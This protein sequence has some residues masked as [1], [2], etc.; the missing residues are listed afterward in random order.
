MTGSVPFGDS[1]CSRL[2]D[3][4]RAALFSSVLQP[5]T[6]ESEHRQSQ[7]LPGR[8]QSAEVIRCRFIR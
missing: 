1:L 7:V 4:I 8:R 3:T 5:S 6:M 2:D